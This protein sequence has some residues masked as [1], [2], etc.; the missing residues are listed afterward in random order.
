MP[1][2][3]YTYTHARTHTQNT[4]T[5]RLGAME[6]ISAFMLGADQVCQRFA[7]LAAGNLALS[8]DAHARLIERRIVQVLNASTHICI[9]S[10]LIVT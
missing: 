6:R 8:M 1:I 2:G 4:Y 5:R 7:A 10:T 3:S 9:L